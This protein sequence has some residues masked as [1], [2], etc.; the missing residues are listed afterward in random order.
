MRNAG[1]SVVVFCA[2][3]M[4]FV[5]PLCSFVALIYIDE[6]CGPVTSDRLFKPQMKQK[7]KKQDG[8]RNKDNPKDRW[9]TVYTTY[10]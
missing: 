1:F 10:M 7:K 4:M 8:D 6:A 5:L 2:H 3:R 9:K